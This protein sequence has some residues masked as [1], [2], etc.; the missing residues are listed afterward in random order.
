MTASC[1]QSPIGGNYFSGYQDKLNPMDLKIA[2]HAFERAFGFASKPGGDTVEASRLAFRLMFAIVIQY[3]NYQAETADGN[4]NSSNADESTLVE[5]LTQGIRRMQLILS[6]GD[7]DI[8]ILLPC[9]FVLSDMLFRRSQIRIDRNSDLDV[10]VSLMEEALDKSSEDDRTLEPIVQNCLTVHREYLNYH[11]Q[12]GAIV[13]TKF[14]Q[15][16]SQPA[17][18]TTLTKSFALQ[19]I[20]DREWPGPVIVSHQQA[21]QSYLSSWA[22][23]RLESSRWSDMRISKSTNPADQEVEALYA[24]GKYWRL[25]YHS[26][27]LDQDFIKGIDTY[28]QAIDLPNATKSASTRAQIY[29]ELLSMHYD[30]SVYDPRICIQSL[31]K[32]AE[33]LKKAKEIEKAEGIEDAESHTF[34]DSTER[35]KLLLLDAVH[36]VTNSRKTGIMEDLDTAQAKV[37][38]AINIA[39]IHLIHLARLP[40]LAAISSQRFEISG[41]IEDLEV[42]IQQSRRRVDSPF[43]KGTVLGSAYMDLARSYMLRFLRLGEM[44]DLDEHIDASWKARELTEPDDDDYTGLQLNLVHGLRFRFHRSGNTDDLNKVM[45]V[46][47][48]LAETPPGSVHYPATVVCRCDFEA[49]SWAVNQDHQ[50]LESIIKR[51]HDLKDRTEL[52]KPMRAFVLSRI[53]LALL[54]LGFA[55]NES[56]PAK[57]EELD[58]FMKLVPEL[59]NNPTKSPLMRATLA[60]GMLKKLSTARGV[61]VEWLDTIAA[62]GFEALTIGCTRDLSRRD[63]QRATKVTS[64]LAADGCAISIM[65]G[66]NTEALQRVEQGRGLILGHLMDRSGDLAELYAKAPDLAHSYVKTRTKAFQPAIVTEGHSWESFVD[67]KRRAHSEL[68]QKEDEIRQLPDFE[69][70][71]LPLSE[72]QLKSCATDGPIVIVNITDLRSDAILVTEAGVRSIHLPDLKEREMPT[73]LK[74]FRAA[75]TTSSELFDTFADLSRAADTESYQLFDTFGA[76][77]PF[78]LER[79]VQPDPRGPGGV[80]S[81]T[82]LWKTCVHPILDALDLLG[83]HQHGDPPRIWWIGA[84]AASSLPF[85]AAVDRESKGPTGLPR[86]CLSYVT[87]SYIPTIKALQHARWRVRRLNSDIS[88]PILFISMAKTPRHQDLPGVEREESA[89]REAVKTALDFRSLA[90]PTP[91]EVLGQIKQAQIVHFACHGTSDM[92]DPSDSHLVLQKKS[93]SGVREMQ[94]DALKVGALLDGPS[95]SGSWLVYLSACS[96]AQVKAKELS[97]ES[98]HMASAFQVAGFAHAVGS[99]WSA[100]DVACA[101]VAGWFYEDLARAA[102]QGLP[103]D[104]AIVP[105]ALRRA[106]LR[107]RADC[108]SNP[109]FWAPFVHYGA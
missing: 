50:L 77:S 48:S 80:E 93:S 79:A 3:N 75:D 58:Q 14:Q 37:E 71:Q 19:V 23:Q 9:R 65:K 53:C 64:G 90:Y 70:F 30:R 21:Y 63:Q 22:L 56:D 54:W 101:K 60:Q 28:Q 105:R 57:S 76:F 7:L 44:S 36:L 10:A 74:G 95:D 103:A 12:G 78:E 26:S 106:V 33:Y 11:N 85:H 83:E 32:S 25:Q 109:A 88:G 31:Q 66:N 41:R 81:L 8:A 82:W 16:G 6:R 5:L 38:E 91:E 59:L 92:G 61:P 94:V 108:P 4:S 17:R 39:P 18:S 99:L 15:A 72:S 69:N 87:P 52:D 34:K 107:A 98:L 100:D 47:A 40:I 84:G 45:E 42:S 73:S 43:S 20:R 24:L 86:T 62:S 96:T 68:K 102:Q 13:S 97:D 29:R 46:L 104:S 49:V 55:K 2:I 89:V 35:A 1:T 51:L 27:G 67:E